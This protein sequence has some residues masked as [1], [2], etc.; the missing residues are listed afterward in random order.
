MTP[1]EALEAYAG[2]V[3]EWAPK[4]DL[5]APGDLAVF[6]ERHIRDSLKALPVITSCP[7]GPAIDVGSGA[8]LPGVP[9]AISTP[10]RHWRLLEPRHRRAAFLEEV[11]RALGLDSEVL[12]MT[13]EEAAADPGLAGSHMVATA[14]A[15]AGPPRSTEMLRPLLAEEGRAIVWVGAGTPDSQDGLL[16]YP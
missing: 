13:A 1:E 2:L 15:L 9:L 6:H 11:V 8:G 5:V 10:Y 14:R 12:S 4:L 16:I 7:P 3:A